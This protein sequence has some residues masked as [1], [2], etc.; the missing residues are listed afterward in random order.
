MLTMQALQFLLGH[1]VTYPCDVVSR[2]TSI[3]TSGPLAG[4]APRGE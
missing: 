1:S 2:S 3:K 4:I